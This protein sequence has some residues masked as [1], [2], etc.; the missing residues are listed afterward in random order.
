MTETVTTA[1]AK[2]DTTPAAMVRRYSSDFASVLPSHIKPD[3]WVR[4]ATGALKRGKR[5]KT[6]NGM[7]TELEI[8]AQ[9]NPTA[10]MAALME[11][12]R[13]GLE[14]GT[15]E[16][17]LTTRKNKHNGNRTEIQG[18][19]GYQ[20]YI[21]LMYRAG[22]VSSVVAEVVYTGDHF[23]YRPGADPYP[24]HEID[25]DAEN[26][27]SLRL[28][29][30]FARMKDGATSKVVVLN[31]AAIARIKAKSQGAHSEYSPWQTDEPAMWLKSATRQLRKWVPTS[32][33][34]LAKPAE[35]PALQNSA[36][37]PL[38]LSGTPEPAPDDPDVLDGEVVDDGWP[39]AAA[40]GSGDAA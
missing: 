9:N 12:A 35:I 5:V 18:I 24:I 6:A 40:P 27:G 3:T 8:A 30:A 1:V 34:W 17:A 19:V 22:A 33:E 29:Y 28:V 31:R 36:G 13:L 14:P 20:G 38:D 16:Y 32:P 11:A 10:L 26:R 37:Q 7:A 21:E 15:E 2:R 25:W 39:E 4:V 23:A